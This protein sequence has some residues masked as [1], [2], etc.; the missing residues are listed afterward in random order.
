MKKLL[1]TKIANLTD[2][3][4]SNLMTYLNEQYR[5]GTPQIS[6][7]AFDLIYLPSLKKRVPQ[8]RLITKVQPEPAMGTKGRVKHVHPM[9]TSK[10]RN[11]D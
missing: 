5:K 3:Q 10:R 6:D 1:K 4:L 2:I 9:L 11:R 7:T 8:H